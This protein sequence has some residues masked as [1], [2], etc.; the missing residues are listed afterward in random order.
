MA[1]KSFSE[2]AYDDE[3]NGTK[4]GNALIK[5]KFSAE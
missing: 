5:S 2:R 3:S 4:S 1:K